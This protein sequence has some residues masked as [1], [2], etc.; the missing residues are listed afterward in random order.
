MIMGN[1]YKQRFAEFKKSFEYALEIAKLQVVASVA[2][3]TERSNISQKELAKRMEV[4]EAQV[5]KI[6]RADQNLTLSTLVKLSRAIDA[7]LSISFKSA[8]Q[9]EEEL[10]KKIRETRVVSNKHRYTASR[11]AGGGLH[12][13]FVA[14]GERSGVLNSQ[15]EACNDVL[16]A[17]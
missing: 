7:D 3:I 17:A 15:Y 4:S 12:D 14:G 9:K 16:S 6:M 2:E 5:S 1:R 8:L 13:F 10:S 11:R